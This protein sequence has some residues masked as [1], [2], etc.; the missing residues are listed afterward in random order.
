MKAHVTILA[1]TIS[2]TGVVNGQIIRIVRHPKKTPVMIS[3][4][5]RLGL[6][7]K[8]K[9]V[10]FNPASGA[11]CSQQFVESLIQDFGSHGVNIVNRANIDT[12]LKEHQFQFASGVVD[13]RS[14]VEFAKISGAAY[15]VFIN[16][17][18]CNAQQS[19]PLQD[20]GTPLLSNQPVVIHISRTLAHVQAAIHTVD[21]ATG[22]DISRQV[23]SDQQKENRNQ[24]G[25]LW[26]EYPSSEE[27]QDLAVRDAVAKASGLFF[28][29]VETREVAFLDSKEC[30]LKE[31]FNLLKGG[32][33]N[34]VVRASQDNVEQCKSQKPN[35][36]ADAYYNL[37]VAYML[38]HDYDRAL[39]SLSQANK[40][41]S[42]PMILEAMGDVRTAKS[43][44]QALV[45]HKVAEGNVE[46][47]QKEQQKEAQKQVAEETLTNKDIINFVQ[48]V[49]MS[50]D[51]VVTMIQTKPG[52]FDT[53]ADDIISLKKAGVSDK[54]IAAMLTKK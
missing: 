47:Q 32:D 51:L 41:H 39:D 13:Q 22:T 37:G 36:L 5:A 25:G 15:M 1:L 40:L 23:Q 30:N 52:K 53:K 9:T 2:L 14:A 26:P 50:D 4:P 43:E 42:E 49:H 19:P 21:L 3:H 7:L 12:I 16:I 54:V 11:S 20:T 38:N 34:A 17:T 29:W 8:G 10:A 28:P 33:I 45:E 31:A 6:P 48:T 46:N 35:H 44:E 27:V 24:G 18:R